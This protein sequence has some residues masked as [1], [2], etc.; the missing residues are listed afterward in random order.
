MNRFIAAAL[1]C[2]LTGSLAFAAAEAA[3]P[4]KPES[5]AI[6]KCFDHAKKLSYKLATSSEVKAMNDEI[7]TETKFWDKAMSAAEKAWKADKETAKK[8]FPKTAISPKKIIVMETFTDQDKATGKMNS[9]DK[10]LA[11]SE[12]AD[13]KRAA[14][15]KARMNQQTERMLGARASKAKDDKGGT[16]REAMMDSARELFESKMSEL[17]GGTGS[18]EAPA[19]AAGEPKEKEKEVKEGKAAKKAGAKKE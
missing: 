17:S 5:Y 9:L 1:I 15:Q 10:A 19:A 7:A 2:S 18:G 8:S 16:D 13:K 3:G 6:L 4:A 12:A 14:D 11:D